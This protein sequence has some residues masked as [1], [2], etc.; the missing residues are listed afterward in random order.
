MTGGA[1]LA[2]GAL[3][4]GSAGQSDSLTLERAL[5]RAERNNPGFRQT[6]NELELSRIDRSDAW[7]ALLPSPQI[8]VLSTG[9]A[10]NRQILGTD[11][12]GNPIANPEATMVQSSNSTQRV[13]ASFVLDLQS[14]L[15]R[16]QREGQADLRARS[17]VTG[18]VELRGSVTRSFL[19][20]QER[21]L[22]LTLEEQLL[23]RARRNL[24]V[25]E[26]LYALA[27][28]DRMDMLSAELE[29]AER[30]GQI[31]AARGD[32]EAALLSLRNLIGDETLNG[33]VLVPEPLRPRTPSALDEEALVAEALSTSPRIHQV[34]AAQ[35][36]LARSV[37][38]QRARW[39][40]TLSL[41]LSAARQEF[42]RGGGGAFLRPNPTE[43]WSRNVALQ[44]NFPD[45]GQYARI[46]NETDRSRV[47][48]RNQGEVV[49]EV[50]LSVEEEVRAILRDLTQIERTLALNE[51]RASLAE[52]RRELQF[53]AYA[54][55][56]GSYFELQNA[57]DQAAL[58]L[59]TVLQAQYA[60]ERGW[61]QLERVLGRPI[62]G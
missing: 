27:R 7:L 20:A 6:L 14:V 25:T 34:L 55:G 61:M 43:D 4:L 56:R 48:L 24:E 39:L 37:E 31:L 54:L 50:R 46:R 57:T 41:S 16:R 17:A 32:L 60:L 44:L 59:R 29:V 19:D 9:M 1:L 3:F 40:P 49:R 51:R 5:E 21:Q 33:F 8:T 23:S 42:E 38:I 35:E 2:L 47:Q 52:E 12:F 22:Q 45:L 15:S 13:G 18:R 36:S 26:R 10:W 58:A 28:R 30:E 53:E 11:P 62:E